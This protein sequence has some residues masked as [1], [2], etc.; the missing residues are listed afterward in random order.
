MNTMIALPIAAALPVAAPAMPST[1]DQGAL[2]DGA[3]LKL[4][5]QIFEH[6]EAIS[7]LEP[8]AERLAGVWSKEDHRMHDEF[9]AT[10]TGPT[11]DERRAIVETMPEFEE[12]M[13]L[14]GLQE[15]EREAAEADVG[16]RSPDTRGPAGKTDCATRIC[17][18]ERRVA[19]RQAAGVAFDVTLARDL[20]IELFGGEPG[21]QLQAQFA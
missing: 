6:K 8:E 2:D 9:E 5:E 18:G 19:R 20:M 4:E 16:N 12:C 7:K 10:Q 13:R 3:L 15:R 17:D 11:F 14:R 1:A 21:A